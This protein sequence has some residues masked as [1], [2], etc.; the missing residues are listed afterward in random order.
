MSALDYASKTAVGQ[1]EPSP[2]GRRKVN[3]GGGRLPQRPTII[4]DIVAE[5]SSS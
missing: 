5:M 4:D 1:T 3:L 2:A